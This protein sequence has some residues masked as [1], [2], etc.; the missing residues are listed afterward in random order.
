MGGN[1]AEI[2]KKLLENLQIYE[3]LSDKIIDEASQEISK[4]HRISIKDARTI[5]IIYD[6]ENP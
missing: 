5:A 3:K 1:F 6:I 2:Q 4:R